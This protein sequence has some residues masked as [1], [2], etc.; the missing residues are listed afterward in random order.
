MS[1]SVANIIK[2]AKKKKKKRLLRVNDG[3][4]F[5]YLLRQKN[6]TVLGSITIQCI[7]YT[8][9]KSLNGWLETVSERIE[10]YKE[11]SKWTDNNEES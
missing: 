2:T 6:R 1:H 7:L 5:Y 4:L 9:A 3:V 10:K 8:N 11:Y